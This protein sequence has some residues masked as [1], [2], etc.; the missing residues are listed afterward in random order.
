MTVEDHMTI[1]VSPHHQDVLLEDETAFGPNGSVVII[2]DCNLLVM[3][4]FVRKLKHFLNSLQIVT[5]NLLFVFYLFFFVRVL[6]FFF[7][8]NCFVHLL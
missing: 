6:F 8:V 1:H 3:G 7:F 2:L 4:S 5:D